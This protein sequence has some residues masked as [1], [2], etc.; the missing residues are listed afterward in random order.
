[1]FF[2]E[3]VGGDVVVWANR[4]GGKTFMG[5]VATLLDLIFKPGIQVRILG[6]SLDQSSRM[7]RYLL[8]L[9]ERPMF[10]P[11]LLGR[12][13]Q[14]RIELRNGSAVEI[15][16]QSE[17]AVRGQRVHKLR[18][19]EVELF[20]EA[21]W[22][23]AQLVTRSGYCGETYVRGC[24]EAFSTMH[25]PF[26]LMHRLVKRFGDHGGSRDAR[27]LRW[28]ALDVIATCDDRYDC[29]GCLLWEDC[30][31]VAKSATGFI[32]VEDLMDQKLRISEQMWSS[33]MLC[34]EPR[35]VDCVY[36][37]F[38][39]RVGGRHVCCKDEGALLVGGSGEYMGGMDFG[40]RS[41]TVMLWG[42]FYAGEDGRSRVHIFD[43]LIRSDHTLEKII[44][45]MQGKGK[46]GECLSWIGVDPAG[47]QR[48]GQTGLTDIQV[49]KKAGYRIRW[50]RSLIS[51]GVESLR[52]YFDQDLITIDPRCEGLIS[53][54]ASYH[55]DPK[56]IELESP[57]KDGADHACDAL[58][59]LIINAG[60]V[61]GG[62]R[63][64]NYM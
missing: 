2:F 49:L 4:G 62:V 43:E 8:E 50:K 23:A 56:R 16:S 13:T 35:R 38:D 1:M 30:G 36:P 53:A 55:F 22:G 3:D 42:V 31:G 6:G 60:G 34:Q 9:M 64:T 21:V 54:L 45:L 28:G 40:L 12:A 24:V 51:E 57:V 19:D 29:E 61:G 27:V 58:R 52:R 5:A 63:Q 48:N 59:Y 33:E 46:A 41:P 47:N 7:Y 15:L 14:K 32:P 18:C 44:S 39:S 17:K 10:K 37:S 26:G 20:D 11:M 25:Q